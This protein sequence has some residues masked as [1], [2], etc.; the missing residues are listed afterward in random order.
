M[1]RWVR[2]RRN[3]YSNGVRVTSCKD[4]PVFYS[5]RLA[6]GQRPNATGRSQAGEA[7]DKSKRPIVL[8]LSPRSRAPGKSVHRRRDIGQMPI[9]CRWVISDQPPAGEGRGGQARLK[10]DEQRTLFTLWSMFCPPLMIG[11]DLKADDHVDK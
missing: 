8:S 3:Y 4:V 10:H 5:P 6:S 9:C 2:L 11:V 7:L 1:N